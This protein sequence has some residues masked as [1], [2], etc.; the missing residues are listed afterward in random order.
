MKSVTAVDGKYR[1]KCMENVTVTNVKYI[2][3]ILWKCMENVTA[4]NVKYVWSI[5]WKCVE[6]ATAASVKYLL[7]RW[8]IPV[9]L[10][11]EYPHL[12]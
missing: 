2:W 1:W 5:L 9:P 11:S 3:S 8:L 12:Y 6:N 10:T 4:A 7:A